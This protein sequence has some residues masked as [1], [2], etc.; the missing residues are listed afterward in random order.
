M[1]PPMKIPAPLDPPRSP[2][3]LH[4]RGKEEEKSQL[5]ERY[6][7]G[8]VWIKDPSW[9]CRVKSNEYDTTSI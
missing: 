9:T 8:W 1:K 3:S 5:K 6:G 4:M 7:G 2:L